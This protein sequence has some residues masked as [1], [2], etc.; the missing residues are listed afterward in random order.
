M[1]KPVK[2]H[3]VIVAVHAASGT[4]CPGKTL[5]RSKSRAP[6]CGHLVAAAHLAAGAGRRVRGRAH[7]TRAKRKRGRA[8]TGHAAAGRLASFF[9]RGLGIRHASSTAMEEGTAVFGSLSIYR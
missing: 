9:S 2:T 1:P 8:A 7:V 5:D 4:S 3:H 6:Q